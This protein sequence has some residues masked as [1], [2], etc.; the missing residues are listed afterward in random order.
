MKILGK[1]LEMGHETS[2]DGGDH[3]MDDGRGMDFAYSGSCDDTGSNDYDGGWGV[4]VGQ[5]LTLFSLLAVLHCT[6]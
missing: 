6:T 5:K 1:D 2:N 3:A 4:T